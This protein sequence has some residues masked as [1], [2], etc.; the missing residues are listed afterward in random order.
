[1]KKVVSNFRLEQKTGFKQNCN[2]RSIAFARW[3]NYDALNRCADGIAQADGRRACRARDGMNR[4][5]IE[6]A[7][8]RLSYDERSIG[9]RRYNDCR[10]SL[11]A[12]PDTKCAG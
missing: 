11:A 2:D 4:Q 10:C 12:N 1:M 6:R 3:S 8:L 5:V 9:A 7:P